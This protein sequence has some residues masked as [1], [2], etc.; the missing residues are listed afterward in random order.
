MKISLVE[1][2]KVTEFLIKILLINLN[3]AQFSFLINYSLLLHALLIYYLKH[4]SLF[5][6]ENISP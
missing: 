5:F 4:Y 1:M 3:K 6:L 2:L